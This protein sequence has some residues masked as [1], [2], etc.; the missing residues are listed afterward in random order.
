[1]QTEIESIN[2]DV[3]N[4]MQNAKSISTLIIKPHISRACRAFTQA[5]SPLWRREAGEAVGL[6]GSDAGETDRGE[7][8]ADEPQAPVGKND[9]GDSERGRRGAGE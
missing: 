9:H 2:S 8:E 1:M 3:L 7:K 4:K 6:G 5:A